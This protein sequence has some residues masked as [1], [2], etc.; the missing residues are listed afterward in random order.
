MGTS[1]PRGEETTALVPHPHQ[2]LGVAPNAEITAQVE[3]QKVPPLLEGEQVWE[4]LHSPLGKPLAPMTPGKGV[5]Q[6]SFR[7]PD[8]EL[9][10]ME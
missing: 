9:P 4:W 2:P 8:V 10:G 6:R 5:L 7:N 1:R 3:V